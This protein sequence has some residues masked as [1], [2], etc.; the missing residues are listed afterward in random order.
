[1]AVAATTV[2]VAA[3]VTAVTVTA[4]SITIA[5][6]VVVITAVAMPLLMSLI[7][8]S[9][10]RPLVVLRKLVVVLPLAQRLLVL[11]LCRPLVP[12]LFSD[13]AALSLSHL[14]GWLLRPLSL[15]RPLIVLSLRRSCRLAPASCCITSCCAALS[16]CRP[17]VLSSSS[18]CT[19]LSLSHLTGWLLCRLL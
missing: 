18:H 8:L 1:V 19:A 16:S 14:T 6:T 3:V 9:L 2:A 15:H 17:L 11:S 10:R 13:C 12:L 7:I 4:V 5:V